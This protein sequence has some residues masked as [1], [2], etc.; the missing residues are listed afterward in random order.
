MKEAS[1]EAR[2]GQRIRELRE[3]R[4][5]TQEELAYSNSTSGLSLISRD[6]ISEIELGQRNVT[7]EMINRLAKALDIS[8]SQIFKGMDKVQGEMVIVRT[9]GGEPKILRV[10]EASPK[11]VYA[12]SEKT[13]Q[14]LIE[15][16]KPML[17]GFPRD[18]VF[19]YDS[20]LA[21]ELMER[22]QD[23][24]ALWEQLKVWKD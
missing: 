11:K 6:Y 21:S 3:G 9:F 1:I 23:D 15:G 7:L 10:W 5:L 18:D 20:A 19:E 2:F 17:I 13:F 14:E 24:P 22:W 12:C 16:F 4:G 8:I